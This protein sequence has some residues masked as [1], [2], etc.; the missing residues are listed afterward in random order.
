MAGNDKGRDLDV[1]GSAELACR[2]GIS[3]QT[4]RKMA[5]SGQIPG[6]NTGSKWL[7]SYRAC[8]QTL[9][10]AEPGVADNEVPLEGTGDDL[11]APAKTASP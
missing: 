6:L 10:R 4:V 2:W 5:S 8:M 1:I 11:A 3:E 9:S 7:F